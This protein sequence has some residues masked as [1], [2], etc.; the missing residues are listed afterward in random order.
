MPRPAGSYTMSG[1]EGAHLALRRGE[2]FVWVLFAAAVLAMAAK[3]IVDL[4]R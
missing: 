1:R 2:R 4:L 3:L